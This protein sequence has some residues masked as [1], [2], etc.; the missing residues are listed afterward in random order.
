MSVDQ[1]AA[2]VSASVVR[3]R[4][5][6]AVDRLLRQQRTEGVRA[7]LRRVDA[8]AYRDAI[9]DAVLAN[10]PAKMVN[11]VAKDEALQ[12]PPG[13][14]AFLGDSPAIAVQRR[15]EL[16]QAAVTRRPGDLGLLMTLGQT[17]LGKEKEWVEELLRW[18]QAAVAAA[19]ANAAAHA[20][21]GGALLARARWTRPS[22]ATR[23]P[24]N[25]T[26]SS[27]RPTPT[28]ALR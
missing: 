23:R 11:L 25:S 16:L 9:R 3:E 27:P 10:N 1:A 18:H 15:R 6:T 26:R 22:P 17:F 20:N 19:P 21:L 4:I 8:D 7:L 14:A 28:W 12:Q 13:F 2:R 5:V 24:S